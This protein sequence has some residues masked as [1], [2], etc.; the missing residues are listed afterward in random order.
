MTLTTDKPGTKATNSLEMTLEQ[1]K[2]ITLAIKGNFDSLGNMLME[3]RDRKAYKVLGYT[4][5]ETYCNNQFGKSV[6]R[7]YQL[8]EDH[9]ISQ[10]L[11]VR[12]SEILQKKVTVK[13]P[14]SHLKPLKL[15]DGPDKQLEAIDHANKLAKQEKRKATKHD[16]ELAVHKVAGIKSEDFKRAIE[17]KGYKRGTQVELIS[18]KNRGIITKVDNQGKIYFRSNSSN[19]AGIPYDQT[20]L[21]ILN[22]S[23][24]PKLAASENI[25]KGARIRIFSPGYEGREG[26]IFNNKPGKIATVQLSDG[27]LIHLP[28]AELECTDDT[29]YEDNHCIG[30]TINVSAAAVDIRESIK[31][32]S[33]RNLSDENHSLRQKIILLEEQNKELCD[34]LID[35]EKSGKALGIS[36]GK[37]LTELLS[38]RKTQTRRTWQESYAQN[39]IRYWE[40]HTEIAALNKQRQYGGREVGKIRLTEKPYQQLLSEMPL[41][42]LEKEGVTCTTIREFID[43]FFEGHDKLVWVIN[44]NF[45]PDD[46]EKQLAAIK[47]DRD[48]LLVR[49]ANLQ[50]EFHKLREKEVIPLEKR[51]EEHETVLTD[52][53][54]DLRAAQAAL[55]SGPS[56]REK[57]LEEQ[58]EE[59]K[60]AIEEMVAGLNKFADWTGDATP[61]A[62][63]SAIDVP[64]AEAAQ[65][66]DLQVE[67]SVIEESHRQR[68][69]TTH[70]ERINRKIEETTTQLNS[71]LAKEKKKLQKRLDQ[72]NQSIL[73]LHFFSALKIGQAVK[74]FST[75]APGE[76]VD[77]WFS[78]GGMPHAVVVWQIEGRT[79]RIHEQ[80]YCI[81]T[82]I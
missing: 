14:S 20:D 30:T 67:N 42:D 55:M 61:P 2:E 26:T 77:F 73:N 22:S 74:H 75:K 31:D 16:L 50:N 82:E 68:E 29:Y 45:V 35:A 71:A 64:V 38:G 33:L 39:F 58:L 57:L 1:A 81:I 70:I 23:E 54:R 34:R 24:H 9:K 12:A 63:N 18:I 21:R 49:I 44:F 51:L 25:K 37:T 40:N 62:E 80:M 72:L 47:S 4:N 3:A 69:I 66:P 46:T 53:E 52:T 60:R 8:I 79:E 5:F 78:P 6:S 36:F 43:T 10:Q 15:L 13:I 41:S 65:I 48:N 32:Q 76:I 56:R 17:A 59:A 11:S 27:A 7:A 28:Y 19:S